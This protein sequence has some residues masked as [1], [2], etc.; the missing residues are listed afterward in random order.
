MQVILFHLRLQKLLTYLSYRTVRDAGV[1]SPRT[2]KGRNTIM[3]IMQKT[4]GVVAALGLQV[5]VFALTL[6]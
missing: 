2:L 4:A 5:L 6:A 3:T 1:E